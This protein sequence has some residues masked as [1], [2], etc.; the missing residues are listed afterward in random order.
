MRRT[1]PRVI[2][3]ALSYLDESDFRSCLKHA[4]A[5]G[6]GADT[7]FI[8]G[9][10]GEDEYISLPE[11]KRL[12]DI[13]VDEVRN[14]KSIISS[15]PDC[16]LTILKLK[17]K[18]A[19]G[20]TGNN[21]AESIE[22][23]Q[24]AER[25]GADYCVLIPLQINKN[26]LGNVTRRGVR[27]TALKVIDATEE[28]HFMVYNAPWRTENKN[29]RT[30]I[31]KELAT[32]PRI[33]AVKDSSGD[34]TRFHNYERARHSNAE[35]FMGD[36]IKSLTLANLDG[37]VAGPLN[38]LPAAWTVAIRRET[39]LDVQIPYHTCKLLT[40]LDPIIRGNYVGFFKY[41]LEKKFVVTPSEPLD[42]K[43]VVSTEQQV[44]KILASENFET[45]WEMNF[46]QPRD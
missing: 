40:G 15:N 43:N 16:D 25:A 3:P 31:W 18:L 46:R 38:V 4:S 11:K 28:I 36:A 6:D 13:G 45:L 23:A 26:S 41:V 44:D 10:T 2:C 39:Y 5:Y 30:N 27:E 35:A 37:V 1:T 8:L 22:L 42:P 24:Y 21:V 32:H 33:D 20:I 17:L 9:S 29:L 7:L 12:I 19:V 34:V 14:L